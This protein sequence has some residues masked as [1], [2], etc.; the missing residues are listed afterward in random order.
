MALVPYHVVASGGFALLTFGECGT[1]LGRFPCGVMD[2]D[3]TGASSE[4]SPRT[5]V[6]GVWVEIVRGSSLHSHAA[7]SVVRGKA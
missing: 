1:G 7:L 2:R 4:H 6:V 5:I 3:S